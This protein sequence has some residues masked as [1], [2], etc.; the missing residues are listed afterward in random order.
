MSKD[1]PTRLYLKRWFTYQFR[2]LGFGALAT[3]MDLQAKLMLTK[4]WTWGLL[5]MGLEGAWRARAGL[6]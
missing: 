5:T 4:A 1:F 3:W 6:Q 2:R